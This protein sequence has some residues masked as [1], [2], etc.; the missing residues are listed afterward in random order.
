MEWAEWW[1]LRCGGGERRSQMTGDWIYK[2]KGFRLYPVSSGEPLQALRPGRSLMRLAFRREEWKLKWWC[3]IGR[4]HK[5]GCSSNGSIGVGLRGT[6]A[7]NGAGAVGIDGQRGTDEGDAHGRS[8]RTWAL[9]RCVWGLTR[10]TSGVVALKEEIKQ[11]WGKR[12]FKKLF[13]FNWRIIASQCCVGLCHT[14]TWISHKV[15]IC[16]LLL[17]PLSHLPPL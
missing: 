12:S 3:G 6:R 17:K 16:P 13:I 4:M 10:T 14:S 11:L 8:H 2:A 5:N 7:W 9:R 1:C 15:C